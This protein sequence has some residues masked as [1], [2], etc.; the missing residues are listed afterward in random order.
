VLSVIS[1]LGDVAMAAA[2][3]GVLYMLTAIFAVRRFAAK[4]H[5]PAT[6]RPPVT[7]LKPV[8]GDDPG[9]YEN[10]K[11]FCTQDYGDV[12][13][14]I[15]AHR[16]ADPAVPVVQKL[17]AD[18]PDADITLVIDGQLAGSNFKVCNLANMMA[19]ARHDLL[20]LADSD[21]RVG[22]DYLATIVAPLEDEAVG[23]VTCLYSG[24]PAGGLWSKL[25]CGF[26]NYGFL[27]SVL[28]GLLIGAGDGCFGATIALRRKTLER[29][30]G[31]A[32]LAHQ[33]ADDYMLGSLVRSLGLKVVVSSYVVENQVLE[34]TLSAL[35]AHELRWNRTIRS[36]TPMGL[37]ASM[38]THPV[39]LATLALPL[40]EFNPIAGL[41]F[42]LSLAGRMALVY[43]CDGVFGLTPLK[44][45]LVPI[46]DALSFGLLIASFCGQR[47]VWRDHRFQVNQGGELTFEGD[48]LA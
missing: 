3:L 34:P 24:R 15:G 16:A 32:A 5:V 25:G 31:F 8:C 14:V 17:I 40:S 30:G 7:L 1:I 46:R 22:P 21:M 2:G 44:A 41:I 43:T 18:L 23:L 13:V 10:L 48:P 4:P 45:R 20:V 6:S 37:A 33:L 35:V 12:Q 38:V 29:V 42:A 11:S 47:I 9:L 26:I 27:P 19:A 36:I 39:A 28:V